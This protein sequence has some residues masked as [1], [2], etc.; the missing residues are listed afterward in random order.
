MDKKG[1]D[2]W[3]PSYWKSM[4]SMAVTYTYSSDNAGAVK[5]YFNSL[6]FLLPCKE[7]KA[8]LKIKLKLYPVDT[9]LEN[10]NTLFFYTYFLHDLVNQAIGKKSPPYDDVKKEYFS[11]LSSECKGC[12]VT[13]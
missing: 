2:F 6:V 7:C 10:N 8:N 5:A 4:H 12:D 13:K 9:Y 11:A 3:G 1:K